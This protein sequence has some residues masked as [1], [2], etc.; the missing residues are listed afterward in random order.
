MFEYDVIETECHE[1]DEE[2]GL[3]KCYRATLRPG[4]TIVGKV[5]EV[6]HDYFGEEAVGEI[7]KIENKLIR[8]TLEDYDS[9]A[10]SL[11]KVIAT[12]LEG[13]CPFCGERQMLSEFNWSRCWNTD[14]CI[15]VTDPA[16]AMTIHCEMTYGLDIALNDWYSRN[17]S[18]TNVP[19]CNRVASNDKNDI[20]SETLFCTFREF[21]ESHGKGV[22][23]LKLHHGANGETGYK[24]VVMDPLEHPFI[25]SPNPTSIVFERPAEH[26]GFYLCKKCRQMF[27]VIH[28]PSRADRESIGEFKLESCVPSR[29]NIAL[30]CEEEWI[31]L[32]LHDHNNFHMRD[33]GWNTKTG[34][35]EVDI[36]PFAFSNGL[37]LYYKEIKRPCP[38]KYISKAIIYSENDETDVLD[39]DEDNRF[40]KELPDFIPQ[41]NDFASNGNLDIRTSLHNIAT[42]TNSKHMRCLLDTLIEFSLANRFQGY[43]QAFFKQALIELR[44]R[45]NVF[46]KLAVL[47]YESRDLPVNFK[48]IKSS[49]DSLQTLHAHQEGSNSSETTSFLK[50]VRPI[51]ESLDSFE[52]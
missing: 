28:D 24:S 10:G 38:I 41:F 39:I 21:V 11:Q 8:I 15:E 1:P 16:E 49:L 37:Q 6:N 42:C 36:V 44:D 27:Y 43:P 5:A 35:F 20:I 29:L 3:V 22:N 19:A 23:V 9:E 12:T 50:R 17:Y 25:H 31:G 13:T 2:A 33:Y 46:R 7:A 40:L 51:L 32:L 4:Q 34:E 26:K 47:F 45:R 48:N 18:I 52:V 30:S 14:A